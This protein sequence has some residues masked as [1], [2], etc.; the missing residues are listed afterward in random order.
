MKKIAL[1][2]TVIL[3]ACGTNAPDRST[4]TPQERFANA[5]APTTV[6]SRALL[7]GS[8]PALCG[9]PSTGYCQ[10][11]AHAVHAQYMNRDVGG[12]NAGSCNNCHVGWSLDWFGEEFDPDGNRRPAFIAPTAE[13]P[14]PPRPSFNGWS[15]T[16]APV[17]GVYNCSNV[18]CHGVPARTYTSTF[19]GGDG[20]AW[21]R[22]TALPGSYPTT[23]VWGTTGNSC[24]AC[25]DPAPPAPW[26]VDHANGTFPAANECSTCHPNVTGTVATGIG[27]TSDT[28]HGNGV[29]DVSVK[30]KSN[31]FGCH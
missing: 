9:T 6:L 24:T 7:M 3:A 10:D 27:L 29:A 12:A 22:T 1:V 15:M 30:W 11:D 16:G 2:A 25:H 13:N 17:T 14:N 4:M 31:C 18:A 20:S 19:Q 28:L 21:T 26:H 5:P 23:P 8:L